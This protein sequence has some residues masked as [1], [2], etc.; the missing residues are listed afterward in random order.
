MIALCCKF[1]LIRAVGYGIDGCVSCRG[2]SAYIY[3]QVTRVSNYQKIE[4]TYA[5]IVFV[6]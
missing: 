1:M 6:C 4:E 3:L 2:V 5:S